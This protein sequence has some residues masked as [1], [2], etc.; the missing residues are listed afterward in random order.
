MKASFVLTIA[1]GSVAAVATHAQSP[2]EAQSSG[3]PS[4][5]RHPSD[6]VDLLA[7]R[8]SLT[9]DQ[10]SKILPIIA[11]RQQKMQEIR[12]DAATPA[13]Q[14]I[15][16][17]RGIKLDSNAK[18]DAVL[19]PVQQQAYSQIEQQMRAEARARRGQGAPAQ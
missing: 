1:L 6:V 10:K 5:V 13:R 16:Q 15:Q 18:I 9:D 12:N 17:A 19:T 4:S 8:L 2:A 7:K 11:E 3:P 14:K